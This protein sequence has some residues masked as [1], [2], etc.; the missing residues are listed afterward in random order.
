M[1]EIAKSNL[2]NTTGI[3]HKKDACIVLVKTEWNAAIV[4]ELEKGCIKVL[5][6]NKVKKSR[7]RKFTSK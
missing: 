7:Y 2:M 6:E 1:A 5:E 3:L 4:N